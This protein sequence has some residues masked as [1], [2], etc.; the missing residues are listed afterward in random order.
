MT[1]VLLNHGVITYGYCVAYEGCR[2]AYLND[3]C[4][5]PPQT[6]EFIANWR[7]DTLVIDCN[8]PPERPRPNHNTPHQA[9]EIFRRSGAGSAYLTHISCDASAW[10]EENPTQLP[11]GVEVA[12]DGM[13]APVHPSAKTNPQEA[14][15][16]ID[17]GEDPQKMARG[18]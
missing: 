15:P 10:L 13:V 6:E 2:V 18:A 16:G 11:P 3:T 5:L 12:Y 4:G 7:P 9:F 14:E 8:Q 17:R 1:P